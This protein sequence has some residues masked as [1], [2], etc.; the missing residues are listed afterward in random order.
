VL[1]ISINREQ[2][3]S[4]HNVI[5]ASIVLGN[6]WKSMEN[7]YNFEVFLL[8]LKYMLRKLFFSDR[9]SYMSSLLLKPRL[10]I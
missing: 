8:D 10:F 4:Y 9:P 1:R 3:S 2:T 6:L 5:N 7:R